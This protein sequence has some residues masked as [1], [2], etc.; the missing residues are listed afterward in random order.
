MMGGV[1]IFHSHSK[2]GQIKEYFKIKTCRLEREKVN[3]QIECGAK[4]R[5]TLVHRMFGWEEL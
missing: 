3:Q 2:V 1:L 5:H 4:S